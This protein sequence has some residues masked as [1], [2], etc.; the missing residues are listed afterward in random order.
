MRQKLLLPFLLALTLLPGLPLAARP[1]WQ[2]IKEKQGIKIYSAEGASN[3]KSIKAEA[4]FEGTVEKFRA[5]L[6]DV[7]R[8]PAWV[9]GTQQA[10][11]LQQAGNPDIL[12]YVET[13]LPWPAANRDAVIRMK[14]APGPAA[15]SLS[16]SS[17]GLAQNGPHQ[18]KNV[19]VLHFAAQWEV[20][21]LSKNR[22]S[23]T[24]LLEVDPGGS[25]PPWI[26][27]LFISKGPYE[28]FRNLSE[29]LKE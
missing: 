6:L 8:Q 26:V 16:V 7:G 28:T 27:N 25:L 5:I 29:L 15:N 1:D 3:L 19:R 17:E 23:V 18:E 10:Y 9:Y 22:I 13:H 2:L 24:Y 14:I 21:T 11:V 12:Y 4:V 20:K